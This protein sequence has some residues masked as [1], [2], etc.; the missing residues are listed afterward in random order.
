M[1]SFLWTFGSQGEL[2]V[3]SALVI[4]CSACTAPPL[5]RGL[6]GAAHTPPKPG[7]SL[8]GG[9][10]N[11]EVSFLMKIKAVFVGSVGRCQRRLCEMTYWF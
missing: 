2:F 4:E 7:S 10:S 6:D 1:V 5:T 3:D 8:K 9:V 11:R